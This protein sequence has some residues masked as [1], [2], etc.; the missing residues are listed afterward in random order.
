MH[1]FLFSIGGIDDNDKDSSSVYMYMV[2]SDLWL[3]VGD[4][5]SPKSECA[6]A[7]LLSG[8]LLVINPEDKY[9][10]VDMATVNVSV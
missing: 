7:V 6:C 8:E 3:R 9:G 10:L 2:D 1:N 5:P 4:L